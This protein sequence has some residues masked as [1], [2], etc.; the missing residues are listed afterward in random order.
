ME[1]SC[2]FCLIW[3]CRSSTPFCACSAA[4]LAFVEGV[5]QLGEV[6]GL[7]ALGERFVG[8]GLGAEEVDVEGRGLQ[9]R[10]LFGE[11]EELRLGI[12]EVE[13]GA[14][15]LRGAELRLHAGFEGGVGELGGFGGFL[16]KVGGGVEVGGDGFLLEVL[17]PDA[18]L[19]FGVGLGW[20]R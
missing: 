4:D 6:G 20:H 7:V 17:L 9:L 13:A 2:C 12:G 15:K 16:E 18:M 10:H 11:V 8:A 14:G 1:A 19:I 5:L 3:F